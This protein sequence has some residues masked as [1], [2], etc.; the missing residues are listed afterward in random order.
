MENEEIVISGEEDTSEAEYYTTSISEEDFL[1]FNE[2]YITCTSAIV[3]CIGILF[4]A[5]LGVC[6][7]GIFKD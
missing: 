2:N 3:L 4:G 5:L 1:S 6:F 7:R